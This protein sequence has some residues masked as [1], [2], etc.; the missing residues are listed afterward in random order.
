MG[1]NMALQKQLTAQLREAERTIAAAE[2]LIGRMRLSSNAFVSPDC[3]ARS[4]PSEAERKA[5]EEKRAQLHKA[6]EEK[7]AQLQASE[8]A[9]EELK[10][11]K[12][13]IEEDIRRKTAAMKID[14]SCTILRPTAVDARPPEERDQFR[15][16]RPVS[17]PSSPANAL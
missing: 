9:V 15:V 5:A 2:E 3:P 17:M 14:A 11:S 4:E 6:A 1:E 12:Q 7:W 16:P 13:V 8:A 10:K